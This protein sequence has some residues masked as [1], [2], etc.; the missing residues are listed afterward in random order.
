MKLSLQRLCIFCRYAHACKQGVALRPHSRLSK[1]KDTDAKELRQF[2]G[3]LILMGIVHQ[4]KMSDY[5][6]K[7][8]DIFGMKLISKTMSRNRFQALLSCLHF[9][10]NS[11]EASVVS[12]KLRK[13]GRL[14]SMLN[15]NFQAV[16]RA[17]KYVVIDETMLGWRGRLKFAQYNNQKRHKRGI[18]QYKLCSTSSFTFKVKIYC[19]KEE[20]DERQRRQGGHGHDVAMELLEG[21]LDAGRT[22]V[23]D[24]FYTSVPLAEELLERSTT[25]VGTVRPNRAGLP[26]AVFDEHLERGDAVGQQCQHGTKVVCWRDKRVVTMLTTVAEHTGEVCDTGKKR[27]NGTAVMKPEP[28]RVYN[29]MKKG[30]DVADQLKSYQTTD[31]KGIKWYRKVAIDALTNIAVV[32]AFIVHSKL[33]TERGEKKLSVVKFREALARAL[34]QQSPSSR[35]ETRSLDPSRHRMLKRDAPVSQFGRRCQGCYQ[36]SR[37]SM[38]SRAAD[39]SVKK[40]LTYCN[41]CEGSPSL[42]CECFVERHRKL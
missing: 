1:W 16:L 9:D 35:C 40:V 42:C 29:V 15:D 27:Y 4:P 13:L 30:V 36:K 12:A 14:V 39:R 17:G 33:Q 28:V 22:L 41:E 19:G 32:N 8:S 10:D 21:Y 2:L 31:R 20:D 7:D 25:I 6:T 34:V 26:R 37:K 3:I 5:W 24:N 18:K 38:S 11:D 23:V